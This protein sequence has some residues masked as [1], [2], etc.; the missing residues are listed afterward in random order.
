MRW[1]RDAACVRSKVYWGERWW[2]GYGVLWCGGIVV[3]VLLRWLHTGVANAGK[4][5][6][7]TFN[8]PDGVADG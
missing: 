6:P 3:V 5:R 4:K 1:V 7:T 8:C 2:E